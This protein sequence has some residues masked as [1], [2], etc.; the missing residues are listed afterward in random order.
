M[1]QFWKCS[2]GSEVLNVEH[3]DEG[4]VEISIYPFPFNFD[5]RT[6]LRFAWRAIK[7]K[8][9]SD[10]ILITKEEAKEVAASLLNE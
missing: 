1:K 10:Q 2:C 7:G 6:R 3:D 4:Y 5:L 8:P 9:Y